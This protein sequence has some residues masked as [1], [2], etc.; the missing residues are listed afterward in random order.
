MPSKAT[1]FAFQH[2]IQYLKH[3]NRSINSLADYQC[4]QW[5]LRNAV[6]CSTTSKFAFG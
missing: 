5:G 6:H 3:T 4:S 1:M 2:S